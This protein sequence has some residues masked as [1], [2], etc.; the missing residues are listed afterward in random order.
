MLNIFTGQA[1]MVKVG[2]KVTYHPETNPADDF[3]ASISYI[4]PVY[5]AGSK[6]VTARAHFDNSTYRIPI[7]SR[8]ATGTNRPIR[9]LAAGRSGFIIGFGESGFRKNR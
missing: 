6:T 5:R 1:A 2:N 4:E 3:R 7:G 9:Q 8:K